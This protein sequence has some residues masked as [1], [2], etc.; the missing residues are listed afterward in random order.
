MTFARKTTLRVTGSGLQKGIEEFT[1]YV[2]AL[3]PFE[4]NLS[5]KVLLYFLLNPKPFEVLLRPIKVE[6]HAIF[7]EKIVLDNILWSRVNLTRRGFL[8]NNFEESHWGYNLF[9]ASEGNKME[10][11]KDRGI[12]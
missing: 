4:S 3:I 10:R 9:A 6:F 8:L 11:I 5:F 12:M 2:N 7:P 1:C